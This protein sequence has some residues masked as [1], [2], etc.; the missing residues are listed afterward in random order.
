MYGRSHSTQY[1]VRAVLER[2]MKMGRQSRRLGDEVDDLLR[3]IHRLE[4][5]DAEQHICVPFSEM[6]HERRQRGAA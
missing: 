5:A 3:A 1:V 4:R 6:M 2:Q